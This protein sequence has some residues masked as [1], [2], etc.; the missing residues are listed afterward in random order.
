MVQKDPVLV[1]GRVMYFSHRCLF[2]EERAIYQH[3]NILKERLPPLIAQLTQSGKRLGPFSWVT[4]V[5]WL[6]AVLWVSGSVQMQRQLELLH[7]RVSEG[8]R[9]TKWRQSIFIIR[10]MR[11]FRK[12]GLYP[13]IRGNRVKT[14]SWVAKSYS[15]DAGNVL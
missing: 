11:I 9:A 14:V 3:F 12:R 5:A 13:W 10:W 15:D 6:P 7:F 8:K 4:M 2:W 1:K